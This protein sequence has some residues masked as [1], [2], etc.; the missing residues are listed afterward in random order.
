MLYLIL[1]TTYQHTRLH[2]PKTPHCRTCDR[3][4]CPVLSPSLPVIQLQ[5]FQML[6]QWCGL[7][8]RRRSKNTT[9]GLRNSFLFCL[10]SVGCV[11]SGLILSLWN[12]DYFPLHCVAVFWVII[13]SN[14]L[15][16]RVFQT[17][18]CVTCGTNHCT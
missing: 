10:T 7:H 15:C 2:N 14:K 5:V 4:P 6:L 8:C 17:T 18:T 9:S 11:N 13:V 3:V 12:W 1:L 16:L